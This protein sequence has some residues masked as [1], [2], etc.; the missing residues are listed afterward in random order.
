MHPARRTG[1]AKE[2][3]SGVLSGPASPDFASPAVAS[4]GAI[5][6]RPPVAARAAGEAAGLNGSETVWM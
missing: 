2:V 5:P 3:T 1:N 4:L 6:A